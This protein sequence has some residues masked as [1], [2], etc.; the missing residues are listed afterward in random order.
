MRL[1]YLSTDPGVALGGQ[2]GAAVHVGELVAALA[3]QGDEVLVL[4]ARDDSSAAPP[5]GVTVE[6]LPGPP[7]GASA[8]ERVAMQPSLGLWLARKLRAFDAQVL[9]ERLALHS[10]AGV[11]AAR[12]AGVPHVVELNAPLPAEAAR[13]RR[14]EAGALAER[15]ERE[16]L[17]SADVVVAVSPPLAGYARA[18]A[19]RCVEVVPNAV[20]LER[21]PSPADHAN[22]E[23]VAVFAGSLRP[24]HG[25]ETVAAAWRLLGASAPRL[26]VLG[27]GPAAA[28][29]TG[30]GAELVGG[31]P[32]A[33]VPA[34]LVRSDIGL[35]P[36]GPDAPSY[37]SPL[38][39]FEYLAAGLAVVASAIPGV[40]DVVSAREAWL[41]PPGDPHRL[42]GAV[43]E[44][45]SAP[46]TRRRTG[47]AGRELVAGRHTWAHRARS[48]RARAIEL[49][50]LQGAPA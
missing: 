43:A 20:A 12:A 8:M 24:W 31:V 27:D 49:S 47:T 17:S 29:L 13:Y 36:Y 38:K 9:Y 19:A 44:L 7:R 16:V 28:D 32:H 37:F 3:E 42:A 6:I 50:T 23:P 41:V 39:L 34:A 25:I 11:A 21:F 48:L 33:E 18:R 45:A 46:G 40:T 26:L 22:R 10:N 35:V 14:L 5:S 1:A 30:V 4:V 2:K 15:L